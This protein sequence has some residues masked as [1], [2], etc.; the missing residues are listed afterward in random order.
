MYKKAVNPSILVDVGT[1]RFNLR[2]LV[3]KLVEAS[4]LPFFTTPMSKGALDEDHPNFSGVYFGQ[5]SEK[6]VQER[7]DSSDCRS[8]VLQIKLGG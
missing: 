5:V 8:R 2:S 3:E 1:I 7:F 4:D 6:H